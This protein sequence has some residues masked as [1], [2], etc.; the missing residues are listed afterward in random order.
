MQLTERTMRV[1]IARRDPAFDRRFFFGVVTT[2]VYC[3]PVCRSRAPNPENIRFFASAQDAAA[4]GYRA[5]K[6]CRPDAA[7]D[8][9]TK[10]LID[11]ARFLLAHA[12]ERL[13]LASL[14]RRAHVSPGHLQRRFKALFGMSPREFQEAARL[15]Q[16]R[17]LLRKRKQTEVLASLLDAGFGS[18][19]QGYRA[20]K[21]HLGMTPQQFRAGAPDET[22][23][24]A[25]APCVLGFVM[26]GATERGVCFAQ[27]ADNAN[28][29]ETA[30]REEFPRATLVA[31]GQAAQDA[32]VHAWLALLTDSV[33][34]GTASAG[35]IPL[36]LR[37]TAFQMRV[38]RELQK[39][40]RGGTRSYRQVATRIGAPKASR[41][42]ASACARNRVAVLV[43]C[44]RVIRGDGN[45]AGYRWGLKRKRALLAAETAATT[46]GG[47]SRRYRR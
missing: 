15:G 29:L 38:W 30:L 43:P 12:G 16:L 14:A 25:A 27:F 6:R 36:D 3:R 40:Q 20:A 42:V 35:K 11:L 37:G 23:R 8:P 45:L 1:A 24:F 22:I 32:K 46:S 9:A 34:R 33:E 5:C 18:A 13:P 21:R 7:T 47:A 28:G 10:S 19:A 39:I 31:A 26:L 2:G 17:Q 41:A 4:A 44:H